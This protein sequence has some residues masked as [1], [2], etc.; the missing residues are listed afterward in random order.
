MAAEEKLHHY[1]QGRGC[2]AVDYNTYACRSVA[3]FMATAIMLVRWLLES[4]QVRSLVM[5]VI[6]SVCWRRLLYN[7]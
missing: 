1:K 7:V 2:T 6:K 4:Y 3:S 5:T